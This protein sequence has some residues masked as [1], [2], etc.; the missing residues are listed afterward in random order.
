MSRLPQFVTAFGL[1]FFA[2]LIFHIFIRTVHHLFTVTCY[3]T[4][5]R[6]LA[7]QPL[8]PHDLFVAIAY[9][10]AIRI[11]EHVQNIPTGCDSPQIFRIMTDGITEGLTLHDIPMRCKLKNRVL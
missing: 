10:C 4:E 5:I 11:F 2:G 8:T 3:L 6:T 9:F 1:R 7:I